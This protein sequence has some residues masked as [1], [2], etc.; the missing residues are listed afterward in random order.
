MSTQV[1]SDRGSPSASRRIS[2]LDPKGEA[3]VTA[4]GA[5]PRLATL[6]DKT[7]G[8][9]IEGPWR[10]WFLFSEVIE[11][12]LKSMNIKTQRLSVN[13][14]EINE[15]SLDLESLRIDLDDDAVDHWAREIDAVVVGLGN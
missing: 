14:L 15:E 3:E 11:K 4:G 1:S 6:E 8:V 12:R 9:L 5:N 13:R 10:S 2:I 7:V